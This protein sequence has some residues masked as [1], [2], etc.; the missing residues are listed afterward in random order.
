MPQGSLDSTKSTV[1]LVLPGPDSRPWVPTGRCKYFV[2]LCNFSS[3]KIAL[4]IAISVIYFI[5]YY[6]KIMDWINFPRIKTIHRTGLETLK[7]TPTSL[8]KLSIIH[9]PLFMINQSL[10]IGHISLVIVHWTFCFSIVNW[11]MSI[12][13]GLLSIFLC[14]LFF[15]HCP[16][17]LLWNLF[18]SV[19]SILSI[20][21]C[22]LCI[23]YWLFS[24]FN[25]HCSLSPVPF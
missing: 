2:M 24:I 16:F 3:S 9:C 17:V 1:L 10:S 18:T 6:F 7:P 5:D 25:F 20:V 8:S 11:T 13:H 4:D 15:I 21:Y 22:V 14:R 12:V 23:V 19:L